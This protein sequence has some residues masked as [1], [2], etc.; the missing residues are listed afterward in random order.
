[1]VVRT[2]IYGHVVANVRKRYTRTHLE[3]A[4]LSALTIGLAIT[5]Y[6]IFVLVSLHRRSLR[7]KLLPCLFSQL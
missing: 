6:I 7:Q 5:L 3:S 2:G 1:M 4:V